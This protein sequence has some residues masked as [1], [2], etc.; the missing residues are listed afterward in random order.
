MERRQKFAYAGYRRY[1]YVIA[2]PED[3]ETLLPILEEF[4]KRRY[5][6]CYDPALRG[7]KLAERIDA[8]SAVLVFISEAVERDEA[9]CDMIAYASCGGKRLIGVSTER[10]ALTGGLSMLLNT[11]QSLAIGEY[12][13]MDAFYDKLF[14]ANTVKR[15]PTSRQQ[16]ARRLRLVGG[17]LRAVVLLIA[18]LALIAGLLVARL[19]RP[20]EKEPARAEAAAARQTAV[21]EQAAGE[22]VQKAPVVPGTPLSVDDLSGIQGVFIH[23]ATFVP[24]SGFDDAGKWEEVKGG[25]IGDLSDLAQFPNLYSIRITNQGKPV[26]ITPLFACKSLRRIYLENTEVLTFEGI[27][28]M[29]ELTSLSLTDCGSV[30]LAPLGRCDFSY[31]EQETGGFRL[32]LT[33]TTL[34]DYSALGGVRHYKLLHSDAP[35]AK[36]AQGLRDCKQIDQLICTNVSSMADFGELP[37]VRELTVEDGRVRTLNGMEGLT[38]LES[39]SV[40]NG[41]QELGDVGVMPNMTTLFT[42]RYFT[43]TQGGNTRSPISSIDG[44]IEAFPNLQIA[45]FADLPATERIK[46]EE[47]LAGNRP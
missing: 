7:R 18:V 44:L 39:L 2:S 10:M 16:V 5:R 12:A 28:N 21:P 19:L 31:A 4:R 26:D 38:N 22:V 17:A 25:S 1:L 40:G 36:L 34:S 32:V 14:S 37:C 29:R 46:L 15:M 33:G 42:D 3:E 6:V 41:L 8:A 30:D 13:G 9:L 24:E 23:G 35:A 47:F 11:W 43:Y 45:G 20:F 27:E